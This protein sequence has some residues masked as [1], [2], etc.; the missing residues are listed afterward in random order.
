MIALQSLITERNSDL[1]LDVLI[2]KVEKA[3][4]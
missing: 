2:F 4:G 3:E 1:R